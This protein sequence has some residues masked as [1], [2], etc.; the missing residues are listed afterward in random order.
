VPKAK[1]VT[2]KTVR[3]DLIERRAPSPA[4]IQMGGSGCGMGL[5]GGGSSGGIGSLGSG[6]GAGDGI[7]T[8]G[9][10]GSGVGSGRGIVAIVRVYL[11]PESRCIGT[12]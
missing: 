2:V 9:G 11:S 7:G 1:A 6:S 5:V 4:A 8:V 12:S 10:C 3:L